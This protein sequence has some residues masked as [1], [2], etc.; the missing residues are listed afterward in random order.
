MSNAYKLSPT[1]RKDLETIWLYSFK[2][3]SLP[4][5]NAYY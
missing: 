5:A 2:T 4:Q 1:A 3:W